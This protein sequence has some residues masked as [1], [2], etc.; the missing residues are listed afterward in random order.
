MGNIGQIKAAVFT[1]VFFVFCYFLSWGLS[2]GSA[3]W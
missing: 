2:S 1:A 3:F